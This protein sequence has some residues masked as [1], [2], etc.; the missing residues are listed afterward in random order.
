MRDASPQRNL[1]LPTGMP[2]HDRR[3]FPPMR[4]FTMTVLA[5][6]F[7]APLFAASTASADIRFNYP[8]VNGVVVDWCQ[9]FGYNCGWGGAH[10][11]CRARGY[12]RARNWATFRP[13]RTWVLA[14][15]QYCS[16]PQ[17]TGFR[18][19]TCVTRYNPGPGPGPGP[20]YPPQGG[21]FRINYPMLNGAA[22][23]RCT[24][25]ATNCGWGGA[26]MLCRM[27]GYQRAVNFSTYNPG[28][29]WIVGNRR[30]CYG[31]QCSG[32]SQVTCRRY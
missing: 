14:N 28:R 5:A 7:G 17:C 30:Y 2:D 21:I 10:Q 31:P 29:T 25:W 23:D 32:F 9:S 15:R 13:G 8:R 6:L 22:V 27:R 24:H 3:T 18:H 1:L 16:G 4:R 20:G 11:Y 26:N 12:P 19:V